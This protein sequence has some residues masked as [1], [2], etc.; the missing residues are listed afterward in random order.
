[1]DRVVSTVEDMRALHYAHFCNIMPEL[2]NRLSWSR[3]QISQYR[4]AALRS[5]IRHAKANSSWHAKRL[6]G[7]DPDTVTDLVGVPIM[8][9]GDLMEHWDEIV[10]VPG[11]S[12]PEAEAALRNMRDQ[13]Y[14]WKDHTLFTSGGTGGRPGIFVY[15]WTS[16][17]LNWGGM[18]RSMETYVATLPLANGR[19]P[20]R[21]R[22]A[23]VGAELSAH[24]SFVVGK[25]FSNPFNQTQMLS[26]WRSI[27][28]LVPKLNAAQPDIFSCYP[29]LI[30]G[31]VVAAKAGD[32]KIDP[33][34]IACGGEHFP[35]ESQRL[36]REAW[37]SANVLSCWGT[38]EAGG[39][40]PCPLS[41]GFHISEDLVIIE[42]VDEAG[43]PVE[44]GARSAGIYLTNLYNKAQPILRYFID[45]VFEFDDKPCA[46]GCA[47]QKV[48]QVHG[49]GFEKFRY[50]QAV[51]HPVT[52][53]LA[54]LE[55]P[56]ILEYQ[57]RQTPHGVH[58]SYR[59]HTTADDGRLR[60]KLRE[61]L[62]SYGV[63]E[64]DVVVERVGQL[65]RTTAGKLKRFVP[66]SA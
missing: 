43:Q 11:A 28:Q 34:L 60:N 20:R 51:V 33:L 25:V 63:V 59:C 9:K 13:F 65:H 61:A 26:G 66:L 29:S 38:S 42:P 6:V 41:D 4:T 55:Q 64:P 47:H 3:E 62:L 35:E 21:L 40:F 48:R 56:Q 37:P 23:A 22:L 49:R 8:T 18:S 57:I 19:K 17:A 46:C 39:T 24:G 10:T 15:D 30:P 58:L 7:I 2:V 14:I 16:L 50:G 45:D 27:E 12:R 5:I 54:V 53:Q 52:L 32:L 31:L 36:A 44:P 1:M